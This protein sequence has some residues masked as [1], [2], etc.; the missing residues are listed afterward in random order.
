MVVVREMQDIVRRCFFGCD[1]PNWWCCLALLHNCLKSSNNHN[2]PKLA[3][4]CVH[5]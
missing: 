4:Y 3:A 1:W 5:P 2:M